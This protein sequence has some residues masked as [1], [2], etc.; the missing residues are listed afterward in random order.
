MFRTQS[1]CIDGN[2]ARAGWGGAHTHRSAT[3]D[4]PT[5]RPYPFESC[6]T[7]SPHGRSGR[8]E[9]RIQT[10]R[11]H[12]GVGGGGVVVWLGL[13]GTIRR[14]GWC[15]G[16]AIVQYSVVRAN[17]VLCTAQYVSGV[18]A[19]RCT[20]R[21]TTRHD[22]TLLLLLLLPV[23]TS[24]PTPIKRTCAHELRRGDITGTQPLLVLRR[25]DLVGQPWVVDGEGGGQQ[26][27]GAAWSTMGSSR[28]VSM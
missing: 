2:T 18:C 4:S 6:A 22:I 20:A 19:Q 13:G 23:G 28:S 25:A 10:P 8:R 26:A 21:H 11:T 9:C 14:N 15:G 24:G 27:Y 16:N 12:C 3:Y 1:E 7:A 5:S 17:V